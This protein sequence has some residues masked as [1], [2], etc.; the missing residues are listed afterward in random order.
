[1]EEV[2]KE[3]RAEGSF[4]DDVRRGGYDFNFGPLPVR[5]SFLVRA[6]SRMISRRPQDLL[7]PRDAGVVAALET[8]ISVLLSR[9][10]LSTFVGFP[11]AGRD[12][13]RAPAKPLEWEALNAIASRHFHSLGICDKPVDS[14]F[15]GVDSALSSVVSNHFRSVVKKATREISLFSQTWTILRAGR[16][17]PAGLRVRPGQRAATPRYERSRAGEQGDPGD[18]T[19]VQC[20]ALPPG[21]G[22]D[23]S[24][25]DVRQGIRLKAG[26]WSAEAALEADCDPERRC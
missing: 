13:S 16:G 3:I 9:R 21:V 22:D 20:G 18:R 6:G 5:L 7:G 4:L 26:A 12:G 15:G 23:A 10:R 14:H 8:L 2:V 19:A 11:E 1:M 24:G 25:L 17:R